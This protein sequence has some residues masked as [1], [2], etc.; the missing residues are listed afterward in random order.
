MFIN[1]I[2]YLRMRK[3]LLLIG[4]MLMF[5]M[6]AGQMPTKVTPRT[7]KK[8]PDLA[9]GIYHTYNYAETPQPAIPE[10]YEPFYISMVSRHASRWHTSPYRYVLIQQVMNDAAAKGQLTPLGVHVQQVMD[11]IATNA[12]G[13]NSEI[14]PIGKEEQRGIASR[15]FLS[16]YKLLGAP[17]AKVDSY[18]SDSHRC[19]LT[20]STFDLKLQQMNPSMQIEEC[21]N[22]RV[23]QALRKHDGCNSIMKE[24][25]AATLPRIRKAVD[26]M[27]DDVINRL[28]KKG[29]CPFADDADKKADFVRCLSD[30]SIIQQNTETDRLDAIFTP[31]EKYA[32]WEQVNTYRYAQYGASLKWG[33]AILG[34]G[35]LTMRMILED[36]NEKI[37]GADRVA[38][39][40]FAHDYTVLSLIEAMEVDGE[41]VRTD[42]LD[43]LKDVWVDFDHAPMSSNVQFIFYRNG[44]NDIIVKIMHDER[45]VTL[46]VKSDIAPLYRWND[47]KQFL[48]KRISD[49]SALPVVKA[50]DFD[51]PKLL[52]TEGFGMIESRY[53]N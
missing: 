45:T 18:S 4:A 34:D 33:D 51:A 42:D 25:K 46:P 53:E 52:K 28:Y 10:G 7:F 39:L 40:R 11:R 43:N 37:A 30:L 36:A 44:A 16:F 27:A 14:S 22:G 17:G 1:L 9:G 29:R 12:A 5:V 13:R 32:L 2:K 21:C 49:I 35:M 50:L 19:I 23:Q 24:A 38:C 26:A 48:E 47:L 8:Y 41:C 20:M 15:M 31:E 6:A 3:T